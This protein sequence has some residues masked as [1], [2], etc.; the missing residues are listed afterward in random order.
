[1]ILFYS[2]Y[3]EHCTILLDTVKRHDKNKK[4][5]LV[6][7]DYLRSINKNIDSRIH[8]VPALMFIPS[9][10]LIFGTHFINL[11]IS[12][13]KILFFHLKFKPCT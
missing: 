12:Y 10:E 2:E 6:S 1:M 11:T 4:I 9:K 5:K 13:E 8:S 3:C 7:I